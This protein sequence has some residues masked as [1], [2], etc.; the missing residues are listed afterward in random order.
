MNKIIFLITLLLLISCRNPSKDNSIKPAKVFPALDTLDQKPLLLQ[1]K[2][3]YSGDI[4]TDFTK[5]FC[6]TYDISTGFDSL[7]LY[8][9][10]GNDYYRIDLFI[11][12]VKKT[13]HCNYQ[14][15][16]S[17]KLKNNKVNFSGNLDII[18]VE[19]SNLNL[20]GFNDLTYYYTLIVA[21]YE[22]KENIKSS[23][24]GIFTGVFSLNVHLTNSDTI[25]YKFWEWAGDGYLNYIFDGY[26]KDNNG[27][28]Y[29]CYFGDGKLDI[30][31]LNVGDGSFVPNKKY[32]QNGWQDFADYNSVN[33]SSNIQK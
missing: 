13:N 33:D 5:E 29:R 10:F 23:K 12:S 11:D 7:A 30:G 27:K 4:L 22:F 6:K 20:Y 16:G 18:K 25:D 8:G 1:N 17:T 15:F 3:R 21:N 9:A 31:D 26:W 14:V 24:S 28:I 2:G 19:K 32:I